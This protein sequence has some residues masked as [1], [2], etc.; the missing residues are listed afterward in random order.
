MTVVVVVVVRKANIPCW[1]YLA[2]NIQKQFL[3]PI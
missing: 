1:V 3:C 2:S